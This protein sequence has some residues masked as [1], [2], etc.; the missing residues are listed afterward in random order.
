MTLGRPGDTPART[1]AK[2]LPHGPQMSLSG[3]ISLSP[4]RFAASPHSG[5]KSLKM[6]KLGFTVACRS[7]KRDSRKA[8]KGEEGSPQDGEVPKYS[9]G[10]RPSSAFRQSHP[11]APQTTQ[12]K[13]FFWLGEQRR[14]YDEPIETP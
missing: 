9:R 5:I 10:W 4:V 1:L 3:V 2:E 6:A 12:P 8:G 11:F 14:V 7:W 13:G